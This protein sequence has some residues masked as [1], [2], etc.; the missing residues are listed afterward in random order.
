MYLLMVY[1]S[2]AQLVSVSVPIDGA[3]Y[4][5][6]AQQEGKIIVRGDL[7]AYS[8]LTRRLQIT[9]S[10]QKLDLVSGNPLS[11]APITVPIT[12][13]GAVFGGEK[14]VPK[15]WY[16]LTLKATLPAYLPPFFNRLLVYEASERKVGVGEVLIIA[17]QS[18]A[19]GV[20]GLPIAPNTQLMD[21]VRVSSDFI[22]TPSDY[23]PNSLPSSYAKIQNLVATNANSTVG[24]LGPNLWYWGSVGAQLA[25]D[26]QAPVAMF[27]AAYGGTTITNWVS[28][29]NPDAKS[30]GQTNAANLAAG[31]YNPG[32]PF[33]FF[34]N[35][36]KLYANTYGVRAV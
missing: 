8:F 29:T 9:A 35:M 4:Q 28:S 23:D 31:R 25:Q 13:N 14:V 7:N 10:L 3:V 26:L 34:G 15:G 20:S 16:K 2:Q 19:Q 17:G 36:F 21:A 18:N 27:N 12:Q 1:Q 24:P 5:Q 33:Y 30:S 32:S 6:N 11:D 22:P